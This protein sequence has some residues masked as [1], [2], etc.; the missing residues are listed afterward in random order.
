[1]SIG[2]QKGDVVWLFL[3]EIVILLG[4]GMLIGMPLA[5]L[6][7]KYLTKML[8]QVG[9]EDPIA[10]AATLLLLTTGGLLAT[11]L[12]TRKATKVNPVQALRYE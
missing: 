2:A 9:T 6:L 1:M 12:P 7:A 10:I 5:L 3:R 4:I 8:Y 11:A